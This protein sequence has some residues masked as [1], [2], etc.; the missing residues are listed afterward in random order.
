[1]SEIQ[2][3]R[4]SVLI[5]SNESIKRNVNMEDTIREVEGSF[6][7][8]GNGGVSNLSTN[9][10]TGHGEKNAVHIKAG[11]LP[12][13]G[14]VTL[15][16]SGILILSRVGIRRPLAIMDSAQITWLRTGA[17]GA[18]AAK[19]LARKN[20]K[21]IAILGTGKQGRAQ[22]IGL[23]NVL[24]KIGQVK[25]WSPTAQKREMYANEMTNHLGIQIKPADSV[26][27]AVADAEI[28]VTATPSTKPFLLSNHVLPGC[29]INAM[30]ADLPG[31]QEL[32]STLLRRSRI[33]VDD[34][35]QASKVGAINVPFATGE[36]EE[37][38]CGT[39]GEVIVDKIRGRISNNDVTVF[40]SSGLGMQDTA[41]ASLIY[42]RRG[43]IPHEE[44]QL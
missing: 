41:L 43:S 13:K 5:F 28:I 21:N 15:K 8:L 24:P 2:P 36:L 3:I 33:F 34:F 30:G 23:C 25:A 14:Y 29:H 44:A 32:D 1:L 4:Q 40:D 19:Y 35:E 27:D 9:L 26:K 17:A 38:I 7:E 10:Q 20:A 12:S 42:E 22:L 16:T 31:M 11:Y 18:V 37:K 6:R 39:L